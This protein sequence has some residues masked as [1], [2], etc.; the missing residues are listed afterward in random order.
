MQGKGQ[1]EGVRTGGKG[2][3]RRTKEEYLRFRIY[4]EEAKGLT[5]TENGKRKTREQRTEKKKE[6]A[7][8]DAGDG[9]KRG[10]KKKVWK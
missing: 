4:I 8:R 9:V 6:N 5:E 1:M 2:E 10:R 7:A 3:K